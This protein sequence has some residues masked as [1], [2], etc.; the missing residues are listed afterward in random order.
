[1]LGLVLRGHPGPAVVPGKVAYGT[2]GPRFPRKPPD[3]AENPPSGG[4]GRG[5]GCCARPAAPVSGPVLQ[6]TGEG[7]LQRARFGRADEPADLD[8]VLTDDERRQPADPLRL[9]QVLVRVEVAGD[10]DEADLDLRVPGL[11]HGL[12]ELRH[13]GLADRTPG[14][15]EDLHLGRLVVGLQV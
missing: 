4:P 11:L 8:T 10:A 6:D 3:S 12:Q 9:G 1:M 7:G 15:E 5:P 2:A 14:S 13:P